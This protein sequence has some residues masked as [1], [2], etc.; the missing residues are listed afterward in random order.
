MFSSSKMFLS[1]KCFWA[2]NFVEFKIF[3][4]QNVFGLKMFSDSKCFWAQNFSG[5]TWNRYLCATSILLLSRFCKCLDLNN[6]LQNVKYMLSQNQCMTL[7]K[8]HKTQC[9]DEFRNLSGCVLK[10]LTAGRILQI[11][12]A[13]CQIEAEIHSFP[14]M[15]GKGGGR[16]GKNWRNQGFR[17]KI[18]PKTRF[19]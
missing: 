1:S 16:C 3:L 19:F 15:Y 10:I 18:M 8:L 5:S 9:Q 4:G 14:T 6:W 7:K 11:S 12:I 13:W 2:Q 17:P